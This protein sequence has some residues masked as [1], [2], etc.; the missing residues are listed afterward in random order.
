MSRC[1]ARIASRGLLARDRRCPEDAAVVLTVDEL[2]D[3]AHR[4]LTDEGQVELE[5]RG[6]AGVCRDHRDQLRAA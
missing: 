5:R 6:Y 2:T 4:M 1:T 3:R